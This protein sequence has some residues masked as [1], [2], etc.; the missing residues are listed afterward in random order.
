M[1]TIHERPRGFLQNEISTYDIKLYF[2]RHCTARRG[3]A[4]CWLLSQLIVSVN[5][6]GL[7]GDYCTSKQTSIPWMAELSSGSFCDAGQM[8]R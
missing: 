2:V 7:S 4:D 3:R 1:L 5:T 8:N 6:Q